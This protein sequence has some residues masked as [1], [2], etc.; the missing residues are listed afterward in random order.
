MKELA[1]LEQGRIS[2]QQIL[3]DG[4]LFPMVLLPPDENPS[5]GSFLN[6]IHH[7]RDWIDNQLKRVG[8]LLFRGFPLRSASDFNAAVE[9]FGWEE[10]LYLGFASRTRIEG[11]VYT[12]NEAPLDQPIKFHH[13]MATFDEFPTKLIFFCEIAPPEGGQTAIVL[14]HKITQRMEQ[15]YP[16]LVKKL[17]KEGLIY[18]FTMPQEDDPQSFLRGWQSHFQTNEKKEAER[19]FA[20]SGVP[21]SNITW[22]DDGRML[23]EV[24]PMVPIRTVDGGTGKKKAW[25]NLIT[26]A[27]ISPL[28]GDS[29][30]FPEEALE[31]SIQ[32]TEEE[33]VEI[34]WEVGDVLVLDNRF[35]Q[36]ARRPSTPPRRVLAA[37]CK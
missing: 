8:V 36:H 3:E 16:Q 18:P 27:E 14:S 34:N 17:E 22:A 5:I 28:L 37:F 20:M 29:S 30:P 4:S 31:S 12:A 11:R 10:H 35:V 7:N 2:Q 33:C 32:I 21:V 13:E 15:K 26:F 19:K 24:G 25:F 1:F 23:F 6:A 9:A